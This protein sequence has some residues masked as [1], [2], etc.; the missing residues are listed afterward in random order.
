MEEVRA[1]VYFMELGA[2]LE[3]VRVSYNRCLKSGK[4][5]GRALTMIETA[6]DIIENGEKWNYIMPSAASKLKE[7]LKELKAKIEE[8]IRV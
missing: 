2:I 5:C 4:D 7:S 6:I 1:D 3:T 8:K